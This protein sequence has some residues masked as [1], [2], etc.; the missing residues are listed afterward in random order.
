MKIG[1]KIKY[2]TIIS[3][4]TYIKD[5]KKYLLC[6]CKCGN[7]KYISKIVLIIQIINIKVY[8]N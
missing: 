2:I 3:D 7:K 6:E 4:E 8:M 5:N 1:D